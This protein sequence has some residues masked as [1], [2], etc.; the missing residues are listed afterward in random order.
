MDIEEFLNECR[1]MRGR[2]SVRSNGHIRHDYAVDRYMEGLCPIEAVCFKQGKLG[3][4]Q[5]DNQFAS[6]HAVYE[7][8]MDTS[9]ASHIVTAADGSGEGELRTLLLAAFGLEEK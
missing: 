5:T 9:A 7:L 4:H 3:I 2:F 6:N 1:G 8:G